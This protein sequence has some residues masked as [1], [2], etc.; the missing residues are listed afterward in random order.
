[1]G[2]ALINIFIL[3]GAPLMSLWLSSP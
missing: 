2:I 3:I 1:M